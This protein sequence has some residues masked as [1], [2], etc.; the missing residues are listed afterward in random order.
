MQTYLGG[1]TTAKKGGRVTMTTIYN[2]QGTKI[3][4]HLGHCEHK[5]ES[6]GEDTHD[7]GLC[8]KITQ[9][10]FEHQPTNAKYCPC[11]KDSLCIRRYARVGYME[12]GQHDQMITRTC[13][14]CEKDFLFTIHDTVCISCKIA[15]FANESPYL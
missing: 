2:A 12:R 11:K 15:G 13:K 1:T 3:K 7:E 10:E 4:C 14:A 6:M 8:W 5:T 9:E